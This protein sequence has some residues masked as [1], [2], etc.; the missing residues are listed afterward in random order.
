M[1]GDAPDTLPAIGPKVPRGTI[2]APDTLPAI[3]TEAPDTLPAIGAQSA[4]DTLPAIGSPVATPATLTA[5]AANESMDAFQARI[6]QESGYTPPPGR[7]MQAVQSFGKGIANAAIDVGTF[8]EQYLDATIRPE[9]GGQTG[10]PSQAAAQLKQGLDARVPTDPTLL[11]KVAGAAG[12]IAPMVL[13]AGAGAGPMAIVGGM[14]AAGSRG[15]ASANAAPDSREA[16]FLGSGVLGAALAGTRIPGASRLAGPLSSAIEPVAGANA[17]RIGSALASHAIEGA[18]VGFA[19]N[20]GENAITRATGIDPNQPLL[21]GSG[22]AAL[23][24]GIVGPLVGLPGIVGGEAI[25]PQPDHSQNI[26]HEP[27]E[28]PQANSNVRVSSGEPFVNQPDAGAAPQTLPALPGP[29]TGQLALPAP[30]QHAP[31]DVHQALVDAGASHE[32]AAQT[33]ALQEQPHAVDEGSRPENDQQQHQGNGEGG[34]SAETSGGGGLLAGTQEPAAPSAGPVGAEPVEGKPTPF[35]R[36]ALEQKLL[37]YHEK[38]GGGFTADD[39]AQ[40][41]HFYNPWT[42]YKNLPG[43]V[44]Q[45]SQGRGSIGKLFRVTNDAAEA[46]GA[47]AMHE[48]GDRYWE[49]AGKLAGSDLQGAK[50]SA[51]ESDDPAM[52][53][54]NTVHDNIPPRR[55][56]VPNTPTDPASIP[57]DKQFEMYGHKFTVTENEDG[58]KILKDGDTFEPIEAD[59]FQ[60]QKIP[61]DKGTLKNAAQ[62]EVSDIHF[63]EDEIAEHMQKEGV[64]PDLIAQN[65]KDHNQEINDASQEGTR[66]ENV[67]GERGLADEARTHEGTGAPGGAENGAGEP[68]Q[69]KS[70]QGIF[71]QEIYRPA[72]GNQQGGLFHEP[73]NVARPPSEQLGSNEANKPENTG[74]LF[75]RRTGAINIGVLSD[76]AKAMGAQDPRPRLA[77]IRHADGP[78]VADSLLQRITANKVS[79]QMVDRLRRVFDKASDPEA[80]WQDFLTLGY[81]Y[82]QEMLQAR[83]QPASGIVPLTPTAKARVEANPIIQEAIAHWNKEIRPMIDDIRTRNGMP[84]DPAAKGKPFF[85]NLPAESQPGFTGTSPNFNKAF[86][87]PA[88]GEAT[89]QTDP[90]EAF[91]RIIGGHLVADASERFAKEV[92]KI[93]ISPTTVVD[94]LAKRNPAAFEKPKDGNTFTAEYKGK[95][96]PVKAID[97]NEGKSGPGGAPLAP[98]YHYVPDRIYKE[99]NKLFADSP[100][101][102]TAL[103]KLVRAKTT[104]QLAVGGAPVH[105]V[106]EFFLAGQRLAQSGQTPRSLIPGWLGSPMAALG[107]MKELRGSDWGDTMKM[108]NARAGSDRGEGFGIEPDKQ[109]LGKLLAKPHDW[110]MDPRKGIDPNVRSVVADAYLRK[111][112]TN[113]AIDKMEADVNAGKMTPADALKEVQSKLG[114]DGM[115]SIQKEVNNTLGWNN[116]QT[117]GESLNWVSRVLPFIG[118]ESGMIPR[119]VG[120]RLTGNVDVKATAKDVGAGR[121]GDATMKALYSLATG[122]GGLYLLK[123]AANLATTKLFTGKA[124]TMSE[125]DEGHKN[126]I[127]LGG[128]FYADQIDPATSRA[129][130]LLGITDA[131][132]RNESVPRLSDIRR[133]TF[134]EAVGVSAGG[135]QDIYSGWSGKETYLDKTGNA[136]KASMADHLTNSLPVGRSTAQAAMRGKPILPALVHDAAGAVNLGISKS[137]GKNYSDFER[138]VRDLEVKANT[139]WTPEQKETHANRM[140]VMDKIR[141]NPDKAKSITD[142]AVMAGKI[143]KSDAGT[144]TKQAGHSDVS[145]VLERLP[146]N[147]PKARKDLVDAYSKAQGQE[148]ED[149]TPI[150]RDKILRSESSAQEQ[151]GLLEKAGIEPPADLPVTREFHDLNSRKTE[152]DKFVREEKKLDA[153]GDTAGSSEHWK[154]AP[155]DLTDAE[156]E[157][158][159]DLRKMRQA[160]KE[161]REDAG[162]DPAAQKA[163]EERIRTFV[164]GM[165]KK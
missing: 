104:L 80:L 119:E 43:E 144:L 110:L 44:N 40:L 155:K 133:N 63:G 92:R 36:K 124:K 163:A 162:K 34:A 112:L 134:N 61:V 64:P 78:E 45:F 87:T 38:I 68:A 85:V 113:D 70:D 2:D 39:E 140:A 59:A 115:M 127:F 79:G 69:V 100:D 128:G 6:K 97:L 67:T 66:R 141:A 17:A 3:R 42:F 24:Q 33:A 50:K 152:V 136:V 148:K 99:Y 121:Y 84:M 7:A 108:L 72:T 22:E 106:R 27:Q 98:D 25:P 37:D 116:R 41:E 111:F 75:N 32:H 77:M 12:G 145:N 122:A 103:D 143:K 126:S 135:L 91:N 20:T 18:G 35:T 8:P 131:A 105:A 74:S 156:Y 117:R 93:S 102:N 161:E 109:P 1:A 56:R 164:R 51:A 151:D 96:Q 82:R 159:D 29:V 31:E 146:E 15:A 86:S 129:D 153:D 139:E 125:N 138:S 160:F 10:L 88:S 137:S 47:D 26:V 130:R 30:E 149:A 13:T 123:Q 19:G 150:V 11:N 28:F 83:G 62:P 53:F 21:K 5:P 54:W 48:L 46:G 73:V 60:G 101:W 107:R 71:G 76:A 132:N 95:I 55:E 81:T 157:R 16:A 23:T 147:T 154:S 94:P 49:I 114:N 120:A 165:G 58:V 57:L 142:A 158:L 52:R 4:P 89:Y 90:D 65:I 118:S 9:L 14:Q